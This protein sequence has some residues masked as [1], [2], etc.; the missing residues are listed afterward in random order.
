MWLITLLLIE[1]V[2]VTIPFVAAWVLPDFWTTWRGVTL[3]DDAEMD[4]P[5]TGGGFVLQIALAE[6]AN[7][8]AQTTA[9]DGKMGAVT[10]VAAALLALLPRW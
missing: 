6:L 2:V 10:A 9:L 7:Q 8:D 5:A 1:T 4:Y 3:P